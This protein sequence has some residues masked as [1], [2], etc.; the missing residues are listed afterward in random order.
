MAE[1]LWFTQSGAGGHTGAD[2]SN[3]WSVAEA[4][5]AGN[6]GAGAG[7]ISAGDT[8]HASGTI[9][10]TLTV[11]GSGSAGN[12][13]TIL[14]ETNA[15]F[16][17]AAWSGGTLTTTG[18]IAVDTKD[19]ITIDGGTNG[20]IENTANGTGLANQQLSTGV[21]GTSCNH[22]I[23]KNL[24]V[25]NLYVR[26]AGTE[27]NGFGYGMG[28]INTAKNN[29]AWLD[30]IVRNCT[31]TNCYYGIYCDWPAG[32]ASSVEWDHNTSS[33]CNWNMG[34]GDRAAGTMTTVLIHHNT[35][36]NWSNWDDTASNN[37]HHNGFYGFGENSGLLTGVQVY[38]NTF[39]GGYGSFA[40][41]AVFLSG[42]IGTATIYNNIFKANASDAPAT[43]FITM[44]PNGGASATLK[45]YSNTFAGTGTGNG[46]YLNFENGGTAAGTTMD[47]K[48]NV[49][50]GVGTAVAIFTRG[51]STTTSDYNVAYGLIGGS[52]FSYS[53]TGSASFKT[54]AQ[55]QAL[56]FDAHGVT[57]N[58]L[59]NSNQTLQSGSSA[60][61]TGTSLSGTF[62]DDFNGVTRTNPWDIG[63][64]KFG[65]STAI[66]NVTTLNVTTLRI[67]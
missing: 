5:T 55:W 7:K 26:T 67:G 44:Q 48:D 36:S 62:T 57:G 28:I 6:W 2:L 40:T 58:P 24:S 49:W 15:K 50:S 13:I 39:G 29:A 16:S 11:Q 3:A 54:F 65:S 47:L 21:N 34:M 25:L 38:A 10:T 66:I 14:F 64:F 41:S 22:F 31:V 17:K 42:G 12:V 46:V 52:E 32:G 61:G 35:C 37:F 19:Y 33:A 53:T 18:A 9:T 4:S 45:V 30:F 27:Q 20:I 56:G 43:G 8:L 59:L 1:D 60:I 63:A 23:V 51:S